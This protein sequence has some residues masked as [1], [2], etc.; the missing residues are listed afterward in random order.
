MFV[1]LFVLLLFLRD[2]IFLFVVL[3]VDLV[4][5]FWVL[6]LCHFF[7]CLS[8]C[9]FL[10]FCMLILFLLLLLFYI[11]TNLSASASFSFNLC[12]FVCFL[13]CFVGDVTHFLANRF[14]ILSK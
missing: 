10:F 8:C 7:N 14:Y 5:N 6:R 13:F 2:D 4:C 9:C 11:P 12:V 1:S 3:V